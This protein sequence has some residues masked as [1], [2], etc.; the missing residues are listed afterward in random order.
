LEPT[1][2]FVRLKMM[3][4]N[5]SLLQKITAELAEW[6]KL[7]ITKQKIKHGEIPHPAAAPISTDQEAGGA[8]STLSGQ[9]KYSDHAGRNI[10]HRS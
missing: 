2:V 1:H 10:L 8:V 6:Q 5:Q 7:I 4:E 3:L 9:R